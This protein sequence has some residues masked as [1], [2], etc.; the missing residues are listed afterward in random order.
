MNSS[1]SSVMVLLRVR[2]FSRSSFQEGHAALIEDERT[3]VGDRYALCI[4]REVAE[5]YFRS[6]KGTRGVHKPFAR[7]RFSSSGALVWSIRR[8][9]GRKLRITS[10]APKPSRRGI[11][12][13]SST[14]S[15]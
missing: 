5:H 2:P 3:L 12:T 8:V 6:R 7:F 4:A 14:V 9:H 11:S 10:A 13:S 1:A 15:G